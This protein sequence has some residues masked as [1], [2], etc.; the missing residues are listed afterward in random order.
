M[1]TG[2]QDALEEVLNITTQ[3]LKENYGGK[4]SNQ[5]I[6][7]VKSLSLSQLH[8]GE[9]LSI[10]PT[11]LSLLGPCSIAAATPAAD[12]MILKKPEGGFAYLTD[13]RELSL[14]SGLMDGKRGALVKPFVPLTTTVCTSGGKQ[15]FTVASKNID[16]LQM[17]SRRICDD[18]VRLLQVFQFVLRGG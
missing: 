9:L 2:Q 11:A 8:W 4:K 10:A 17:I 15:A 13:R 16:H 1:P 18:R 6:E 3:N 7:E 14:R 12:K 5:F